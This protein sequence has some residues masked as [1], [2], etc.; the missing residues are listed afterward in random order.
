MKLLCDCRRQQIHSF[1]HSY[2]LL[3]LSLLFVNHR[4]VKLVHI[5]RSQ[6]FNACRNVAR[7]STEKQKSSPAHNAYIR[8][9]DKI[10]STKPVSAY[11]RLCYLIECPVP[12]SLRNR[13]STRQ[14]GEYYILGLIIITHDGCIAATWVGRS[15]ASVCLSVRA[16]KGKRLEL[17]T[18]NL[19]HIYSIVVAGMH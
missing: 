1:I 14:P 7:K 13:R 9:I 11:F 17:S 6:L 2:I 19:V 10:S 12:L 16:L 18:P 5:I 3:L 8:V 4:R 15:I